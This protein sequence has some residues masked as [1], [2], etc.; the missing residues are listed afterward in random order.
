[1]LEKFPEGTTLGE[2]TYMPPAKE[3]M[4]GAI[5]QDEARGAY[6]LTEFDFSPT[7]LKNYL[8]KSENSFKNDITR[9]N[10]KFVWKAGA[11]RF[12]LQRT[13]IKV[14]SRRVRAEARVQNVERTFREI[15]SRE[16]VRAEA[17][18]LKEW[19]RKREIKRYDRHLKQVRDLILSVEIGGSPEMGV[20]SPM[21]EL[22]EL[23]A[24]EIDNENLSSA[25]YYL[26]QLPDDRLT[27]VQ[28]LQK[29]RLVQKVVQYQHLVNAR[30][31]ELGPDAR[32]ESRR[33]VERTLREIGTHGH[34][35][36][37]A[38][39]EPNGSG[40]SKRPGTR[41]SD[42]IRSVERTLREIGTHGHVR[43]EARI[44]PD[45]DFGEQIAS[46]IRD[47][48]DK[49]R[50]VASDPILH[51]DVPLLREIRNLRGR[52]QD[53]TSLVAKG[54]QSVIKQILLIVDRIINAPEQDIVHLN[55]E[56]H[57]IY[58]L[59][60]R[61]EL[62]LEDGSNPLLQEE[63]AV[64]FAPKAKQPQTKKKSAPAKVEDWKKLEQPMFRKYGISKP[65]RPEHYKDDQE[66]R[67][68][69][70]YREWQLDPKRIGY[71]IDEKT[72]FSGIATETLIQRRALWL[73][74]YEEK[75]GP[76]R[77]F[78]DPL[79]T[80]ELLTIPMLRSM[81]H[82]IEQADDFEEQLN[83]E[84]SRMNLEGRGPIL[85]TLE[86]PYQL[87]FD[88]DPDP[89]AEEQDFAANRKRFEEWAK[90]P[91]ARRRVWGK[92]PVRK[93]GDT[94][95]I[96][97]V[98]KRSR[99]DQSPYA[100]IRSRSLMPGEDILVE[101][102][103]T[104]HESRVIF[105]IHEAEADQWRQRE[106]KDVRYYR[107]EFEKLLT[108]KEELVARFDDWETQ[109]PY[110]MAL[111]REHHGRIYLSYDDRRGPTF[112]LIPLRIREILKERG[113]FLMFRE[114]REEG[115]SEED[116]PRKVAEVFYQDE[117]GAPVMRIWEGALDERKNEMVPFVPYR[118]PQ[119]LI[120]EDRYRVQF[121]AWRLGFVDSLHPPI[122][123]ED[124]ERV[125]KLWERK[126]FDPSDPE[127]TQ[128]LLIELISDTG[129]DFEKAEED[130]NLP[131]LDGRVLKKTDRHGGLRLYPR[132][133]FRVD[134]RA[135]GRQEAG[136][137]P[138][139][140]SSGM[141]STQASA[142]EPD[143]LRPRRFQF[144]V[145][146]KKSHRLSITRTFQIGPGTGKA[147]GQHEFEGK[148]FDVLKITVVEEKVPT[149]GKLG[150]QDVVVRKDVN[151]IRI[152]S[153]IEKGLPIPEKRQK[154]F[155]R[156][157]HDRGQVGIAQVGRKEVT[158]ITHKQYEGETAILWL[159]RTGEGKQ[160]KGEYSIGFVVPSK[161][162]LGEEYMI[163]SFVF[164]RD[165]KILTGTPEPS[166]LW[167]DQTF[168]LKDLPAAAGYADKEL[169]RG[170]ALDE[171]HEGLYEMSF[172]DLKRHGFLT[173]KGQHRFIYFWSPDVR[174]EVPLYFNKG[175]H[176]LID[177]AP[178]IAGDAWTATIWSNAKTRTTSQGR[179]VILRPALPV[180]GI[181]LLANKRFTKARPFPDARTG[182]EHVQ[183]DLLQVKKTWIEG[184]KRT[185]RN[186]QNVE[187]FVL[188]AHW[189][190]H[191]L[192]NGGDTVA[193][194]QKVKV[195][196]SG[197][198]D[199][200]FNLKDQPYSID[201]GKDF[202]KGETIATWKTFPEL[203]AD[204]RGL[205]YVNSK[206]GAE[207][208]I[209][210]YE[211]KQFLPPVEKVSGRAESRADEI[212]DFEPMTFQLK[213][214]N[215]KSH[216]GVSK[217]GVWDWTEIEMGDDP[218]T[219]ENFSRLLSHI[220]M[221]SMQFVDW[222]K[223]VPRL[224]VVTKDPR[225]QEK[226]N[227]LPI[228]IAF[229]E[230]ERKSSSMVL[231]FPRI[232]D[233]SGGEYDYG[234]YMRFFGGNEFVS[235]MLKA[236][237]HLNM[238]SESPYFVVNPH[239]RRAEARSEE[240][241]ER[242]EN[243]IARIKTDVLN[244]YRNPLQAYRI[245]LINME[246]F[247][248]RFLKDLDQLITHDDGVDILAW[249]PEGIRL[250]KEKRDVL[251]NLFGPRNDFAKEMVR[252]GIEDKDEAAL[253][254][255]RILLSAFPGWVHDEEVERGTNA[256]LIML[257][258]AES[259][260]SVE[261]TL[262]EIGTHGHVRAKS[263]GIATK[264]GLSDAL[265][266][267]GPTVVFADMAG[268]RFATN[269]LAQETVAELASL[270]KTMGDRLTV[271]LYNAHKARSEVRDLIRSFGGNQIELVEGSFIQAV[272]PFV[273]R[274]EFDLV[275]I[276]RAGTNALQEFRKLG[277]KGRP[278]Y[279]LRG[280]SGTLGVGLKWLAALKLD[281]LVDD[282]KHQDGY[283]WIAE[284]AAGFMRKLY[285]A[286][287]A[288]VFAQ[289]A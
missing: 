136:W 241:D 274:T 240:D 97:F 134:W 68:D 19:K 87:A 74:L 86:L 6:R 99:P 238:T 172:K 105:H 122:P 209:V 184:D 183:G 219:F 124:D 251:N 80:P 9:W 123:P 12:S 149:R 142:S 249:A 45:D 257:N 284:Q 206:T 226:M 269:R 285:E 35:R 129:F 14:D 169:I 199:L 215:E 214:F 279:F 191:W 85:R 53:L 38:R 28:L 273:H 146:F 165:G 83:S 51:K 88:D 188:N 164:A 60:Q 162:F 159:R 130:G 132:M 95:V 128:S 26:K 24:L 42:S 239:G 143:G 260:R 203:S 244:L 155:P 96:H 207:K 160:G 103:P 135:L 67:N 101:G 220:D 210:L 222:E 5:F 27:E 117:S 218:S 2:Y 234:E 280:F 144:T 92:L 230:T 204:A 180:R 289:A 250:E 277:W 31:K 168:D 151:L 237:V 52:L 196:R 248:R 112:I 145:R 36:A 111:R 197:V 50:T 170:L 202:T 156:R 79:D 270:T 266:P 55:S 18:G 73:K 261:R 17:R 265:S 189:F 138:T 254:F 256:F 115:A 201:L 217:R 30:L 288:I 102:F 195:K 109:M 263:T 33:N 262:R 194:P 20:P 3:E 205:H 267:V 253:V 252:V 61:H 48:A 171:L 272:Q 198:T 118:E 21:I 225:V 192:A 62:M 25:Q 133:K 54:Q 158:F 187:N 110:P 148:S 163:S 212:E 7:K 82:R 287:Y 104:P 246:D 44:T 47:I 23:E 236:H 275:H 15:G 8:R 268:P 167:V 231:R 182:Y 186:M 76:S 157:I 100:A 64:T 176:L 90:V 71:P 16:H 232:I 221:S 161:T 46:V 121:E 185:W 245:H 174:M 72:L 93:Q 70:L 57:E 283:Y 200:P 179:K 271:K 264:R 34:V 75:V 190:R 120:K 243:V 150:D 154:L 208:D 242:I 13:Y 56:L 224:L 1:M 114:E 286:R 125:P 131:D 59:I 213:G 223:K 91:F 147:I 98:R 258:R 152:L 229:Y 81:I 282:I 66:Y 281:K 153:L 227:F 10:Y 39:P 228:A 178:H 89:L 107:P 113:V 84:L 32:A 137:V 116:P 211:K 108:P 173:D 255:S 69:L 278:M 127:G 166:N 37:E 216:R 63:A 11:Q 40:T 276:S 141:V 77:R 65:E 41:R 4:N 29:E 139:I 119:L 94:G 58:G 140:L 233:F 49:K 193:K 259:R 78:F 126:K 247:D 22:P 177:P 43:A 106:R 235:G 181:I 175:F